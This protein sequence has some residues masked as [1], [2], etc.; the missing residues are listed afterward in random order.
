MVWENECKKYGG[1][2][3]IAYSF[4]N[5]VQESENAKILSQSELEEGWKAVQRAELTLHRGLEKIQ[6]P[7]VRNLLSRNWFQ[8]KNS[9][10]VYA[11]G[12]FDGYCQERVSGGTG[13]TVQMAIDEGKDVFFFDQ[14]DSVWYMYCYEDGE[15]E[16]VQK[17][18]KLTEN[19]AGVGTRNINE[20][21]INAI[22]EVVR[23]SLENKL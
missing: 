13:W 6:F 3:T 10:A 15:F 23:E 2:T 8:V 4:Y 21:G 17:I 5:H 18:P 1:I 19:F 14:N 20:S 9:D 16:R 7:Y 22:Q 11:I 12:T